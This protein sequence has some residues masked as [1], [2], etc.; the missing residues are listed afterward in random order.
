MKIL[1]IENNQLN[2][3]SKRTLDVFLSVNIDLIR[4]IVISEKDNFLM[5][6]VFRKDL[7]DKENVLVVEIASRKMFLNLFKKKKNASFNF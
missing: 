6:I 5:E 7:N 1:H 4:R 2:F 3:I